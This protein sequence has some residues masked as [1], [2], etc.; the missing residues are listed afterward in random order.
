MYYFERHRQ[1]LVL[2][3]CRAQSVLSLAREAGP[4]A[5]YMV[6]IFWGGNV[7]FNGP[8]LSALLEARCSATVLEAF[9]SIWACGV[10]MESVQALQSLV[11][12]TVQVILEAGRVASIMGA[13]PHNMGI[14]GECSVLDLAQGRGGI[15]FLDFEHFVLGLAAFAVVLVLVVVVVGGSGGW[16]SWSL[17]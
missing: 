14:L 12:R 15:V 11:C 6:P 3:R 10:T 9:D 4:L 7:Q 2:R 13:G 16:W 1:G 5:P 8:P 17:W